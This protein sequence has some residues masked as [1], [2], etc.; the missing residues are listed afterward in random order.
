MSRDMFL[1][2]IYLPVAFTYVVRIR[3]VMSETEVVGRELLV[4]CF[5]QCFFDQHPSKSWFTFLSTDVHFLLI[6]S[7][8]LFLLTSMFDDLLT[9]VSL[10]KQITDRDI[11][12]GINSIN[13]SSCYRFCS[14]NRS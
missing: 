7:V 11:Y 10:R 3:T 14:R 9:Y 4:N 12:D 5:S 2:F 13:R 1:T 8:H 6:R